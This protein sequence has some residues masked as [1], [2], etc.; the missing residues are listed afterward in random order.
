MRSIHGG[1]I[2]ANQKQVIESLVRMPAFL[3]AHPA[4]PPDTYAGPADALDDACGNCAPPGAGIFEPF[5][6]T[7]KRGGGTGLGLST[8]Y[9][10]V[11]HAGGFINVTSVVGRG[12][13]F[14]VLWPA[15]R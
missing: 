13:T 7:K 2:Y 5:F 12:T 15:V 9:G 4:S 6:T 1:D 3:A 11:K 8:V 10:I 14:E